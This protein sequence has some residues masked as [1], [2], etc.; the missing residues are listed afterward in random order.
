MID[1]KKK[2]LRHIANK[3]GIKATFDVNGN[4]LLNKKVKESFRYG[5]DTIYV[6][7]D[8]TVIVKKE[9]GDSVILNTDDTVEYLDKD[10]KVMSK[11]DKKKGVVLDLKNKETNKFKQIRVTD[12]LNKSKF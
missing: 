11:K 5:Y 10:G 6:L 7:E 12:L 8:D 3:Y 9:N 2:Q 4:K 1:D